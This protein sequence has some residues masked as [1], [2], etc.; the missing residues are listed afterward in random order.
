MNLK[1]TFDRS[2]ASLAETMQ[3]RIDGPYLSVPVRHEPYYMGFE[4]LDRQ[5]LR[6]RGSDLREAAREAGRYFERAL[7][8][9]L[10]RM[11]HLL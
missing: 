1:I 3:V 7:V 5:T 4:S 9:E 11:G 2:A 10:R 8:T 6:D